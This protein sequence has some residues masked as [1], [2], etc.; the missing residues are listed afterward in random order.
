MAILY[1]LEK[2]GCAR[3]FVLIF[4]EMLIGLFVLILDLGFLMLEKKILRFLEV[5]K[6]FLCVFLVF[7]FVV[8]E[9]GLDS[10]LEVFGQLFEGRVRVFECVFGCLFGVCFLF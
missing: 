10:C 2:A 7:Y 9:R 4:L 8:V 1:M 5:S 6:N 3:K